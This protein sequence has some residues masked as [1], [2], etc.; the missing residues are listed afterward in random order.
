[1]SNHKQ[2]TLMKNEKTYV[3]IPGG[4]HGGWVYDPITESLERLGK[5]CISLTLPGL[6][7][8][9]VA[10]PNRIINLDTHIQLIIDVFLKISD[11]FN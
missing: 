9:S 10:I 5:K 1:M 2:Q 7:I 4:W 6:E 8:Q 3:F 11:V